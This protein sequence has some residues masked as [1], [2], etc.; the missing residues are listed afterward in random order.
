[1]NAM[2]IVICA[3]N[4]II[5]L[6][7]IYKIINLSWNIQFVIRQLVKKALRF[8]IYIHMSNLLNYQVYSD[9][10]IHFEQLIGNVTLINIFTHLYEVKLL[11]FSYDVSAFI[12]YL[13]L[14]RRKKHKW[15]THP[16][17]TNYCNWYTFWRYGNTEGRTT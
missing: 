2:I 6:A 5:V 15:L 4:T 12:I 3:K 8:T 9:N 11:L 14:F 16:Q 13:L 7:V 1:M 10:H 17:K